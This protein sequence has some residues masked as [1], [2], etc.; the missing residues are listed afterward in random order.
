M[1]DP[2]EFSQT[3]RVAVILSEWVLETAEFFGD[4]T[5]D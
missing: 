2:E 4:E 3:L 5:R 1:V